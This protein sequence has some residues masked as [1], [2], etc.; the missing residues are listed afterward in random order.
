VV[1][2]QWVSFEEHAK[3]GTRVHTWGDVVHTGV[4]IAGQSAEQIITRFT[5]TWYE[6]FRAVCDS[7]AATSGD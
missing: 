3:K 5:E 1:L 4:T 7:I 2:A 6:N